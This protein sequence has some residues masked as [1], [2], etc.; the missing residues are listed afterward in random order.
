MERRGGERRLKG[1]TPIQRATNRSL[2]KR[3]A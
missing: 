1:D 2:S 3:N